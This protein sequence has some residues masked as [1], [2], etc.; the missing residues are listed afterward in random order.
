MIRKRKLIKIGSEASVQAAV[1]QY[2]KAQYP[3]V[4]YCASAG[5]LKTSYAQ[6][7]R[8]KVTGYKKGF[9]DIQICEPF[10]QYHGLFIE[11]KKEGGYLSK[12]QKE[13]IAELKKR[14]YYA[15]VCKSFDSAKHVIDG[16]FSGNI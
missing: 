11:M 2:L 12:E 5:G 14:G 1:I 7:A 9:P 15:T 6:A 8:M 13:W 3:Q 10:G 16:Y 4:L